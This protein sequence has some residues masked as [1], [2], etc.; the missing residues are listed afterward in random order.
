MTPSRSEGKQEELSPCPYHRNSETTWA[1][2]DAC[3]SRL[4][5]K[6]KAAE[7]ERDIYLELAVDRCWAACL[8]DPDECTG[9]IIAEKD[10][11]VA[12]RRGKV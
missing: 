1:G 7:M 6:L 3:F 11:L 5:A 4:Q 10:R 12:E 8:H 2:C 9:L